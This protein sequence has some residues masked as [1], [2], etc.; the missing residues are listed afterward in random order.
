M[1][2]T[3]PTAD[4]WKSLVEEFSPEAIA[5]KLLLSHV[6]YVFRDEPLKFALFRKT[7]ADAFQVE[8]SNVF[9]VGS[10][11]AGRSLKGK[12]ISK[13][14]SSKSDID[15]LIVSE[16]LFTNYVMKSLAWIKECTAP[17]FKTKPHPT[18][19]SISPAQ[20]KFIY[21][22][23]DSAH[24][25]I[26]RPDSLPPE[27][28]ARNEFFD[29]FSAVSL[30]TLGLQLSEDTVAKVNGRVARSFEDAVRDLTSSLSRLRKEF[31]NEPVEPVGEPTD[32]TSAGANNVS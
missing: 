2:T 10:A 26:W 14:Y 18:S 30:K 25:G 8:P 3:Y 7:I 23:A 13:E 1:A 17:D 4:Q 24:K 9:I 19:P 32:D 28:D 27:A 12:S 21:W 20:T 31:R 22:L 11:M 29:K 15:T 6:P 16:H 5:Y